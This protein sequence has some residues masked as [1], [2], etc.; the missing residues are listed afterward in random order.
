ML[1]DMR[2]TT[3]RTTLAQQV[4]TDFYAKHPQFANPAGKA[5]AQQVAQSLIASRQAAGKPIQW[6]ADFA[7]D[8]SEGMTALVQQFAGQQAPAAKTPFKP[9]PS[10]RPA[11]Q[12]KTLADDIMEVVGSF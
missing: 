10:A 1:N 5:L 4:Q 12:K 8:L 2:S 7:K 11:P 6:D 3:E 9:G